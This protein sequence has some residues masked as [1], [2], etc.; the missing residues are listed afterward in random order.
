MKISD[1]QSQ[2]QQRWPDQTKCRADRA[3]STCEIECSHAVLP[4]L[5]GRLFLSWNFSFAGLVVEEL[6]TEWQLR[7][8]FYG[9]QPAE[10]VHV[11]VQAQLSE[12]TFPSIATCNHT[13]PEET[14]RCAPV[15]GQRQGF[16]A[17]RSRHSGN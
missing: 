3:T 14:N 10:L 15:P 1:L 8:C 11:L 12:R 7:Y 9:D 13:N 5:C 6:S 16:N 17:S 4:E 2:V